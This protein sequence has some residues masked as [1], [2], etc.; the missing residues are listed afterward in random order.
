MEMQRMESTMVSTF[1]KSIIFCIREQ[2]S[3]QFSKI[4]FTII[5]WWWLLLLLH[6][7]PSSLFVVKFSSAIIHTFFATTTSCII[8]TDCWGLSHHLRYRQQQN[9]SNHYFH[10]SITFTI[11][12]FV[13]SEVWQRDKIKKAQQVSSSNTSEAAISSSHRPAILNQNTIMTSVEAERLM[14]RIIQ[15]QALRF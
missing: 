13:L 11:T 15:E 9:I 1:H 5:L 3:C 2:L 12:S 7:L 8:K 6:H 4:N 14:Q 10:W